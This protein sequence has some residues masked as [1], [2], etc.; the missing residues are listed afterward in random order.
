MDSLGGLLTAGRLIRFGMTRP[1]DLRTHVS[2]A[3][4]SS[5]RCKP[6]PYELPRRQLHVG[7]AA[8]A[9]RFVP[10]QASWNNRPALAG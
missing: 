10:N 1:L 5:V 2:A 8:P 7:P 9:A 3:I 6:E 4:G